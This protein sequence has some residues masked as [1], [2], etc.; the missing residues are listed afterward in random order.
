MRKFGLMVL[1]CTA[2]GAVPQAAASAIPQ[3]EMPGFWSTPTIAGYGKIHI[4][5]NGIHRPDPREHY[6]I[7]LAL[8]QAAK[9][10]ATVNGSLD[11]V[12]RTVNL[13]VA[14]GV[15]LSHLKVAAVAYGGATPIVLDNAH[16]RAAFGDDNPNLALLAALKRAGVEVSVCAQA[17]GEHGYD[18]DWIDHNARLSV[19]GLT[20]VTVLQHQGYALMPE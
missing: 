5:A 13:Y 1:A 11:H 7:V 16:Y 8:T 14:S 2:L 17:M 19:S 15:P 3:A 4:P 20:T 10:P 6:K 9:D 18:F 12:A